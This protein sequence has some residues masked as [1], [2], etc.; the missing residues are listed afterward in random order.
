[1]KT[2]KTSRPA[3]RRLL[4]LL[5]SLALLL[6]A[7]APAGPVSANGTQAP[8]AAES[9]LILDKTAVPDGSG[10]YTIRLEAYTTGRVESTEKVVPTDIVLVLDQSGS[11]DDEITV[12]T[13]DYYTALWSNLN[14]VAASYGTLY[15]LDNGVYREVSVTHRTILGIGTYYYRYTDANG[16]QQT[17]ES[18]FWLGSV[19]EPLNGNLYAKRTANEQISRL[20]ALKDAAGIF[21]GQVAESAKGPDGIAG[22]DDDVNHRLA[23]VGFADSGNWY[24]YRNTELFVGKDAY[25]YGSDAPEHYGEALQDMSTDEGQ[26]NIAA[27]INELDANGA[28]Y[29]QYGMEMANGILNTVTDPER[30]KVVILFTDGYPGQNSSSYDADVANATI[31]QAN[32]AKS[33][34]AVVYAV[35]IFDGADPSTPG[36]VNGNAT[37]QSN[38]YMQQVS[39]NNGKVQ[40]PSYYLAASDAGSLNEIFEQISD[41]ISRPDISLGADT[42][43]RDIVSPYFT[44]PA[45]KA[46]ITVGTAAYNGDGTF[47]DPVPLADPQVELKSDGAMEVKGFDFDQNFVTDTAKA[48]GTYGSKLVITFTVRPKGGF[49]GGNSVP[50]NGEASGVYRGSGELVELFPQPEVN[51]PLDYD[52]ATSDQTIYLG[53]TADLAGRLGHAQ[54]YVPDGVNNAFVNIAYQVKDPA[55]TVVGAYT[56]PAGQ[57]SGFWAWAGSAS[58]A[59]TQDTRYTVECTV[60]PTESPEGGQEAL[61]V[62]GDFTVY[63]RSGSLTITKWGGQSGETYLFRILKDGAA[64]MTVPVE[65]G[66]S[67]TVVQLAKGN[68]TV[69]EDATWSWRYQSPRYNTQTVTF[70]GETVQAEVVCTNDDRDPYWL[71]GYDRA[72]NRKGGAD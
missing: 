24:G 66:G 41:S 33:G 12:G 5:L 18:G 3:G 30:N 6:A 43:I 36:D 52:Y 54:G 13:R 44:P 28:T 65:A 59:L 10:G 42:V 27:S 34:G 46:S 20:E 51:V 17:L 22:T 31:A 55:G 1:M 49:F 62:P 72:A 26:G 40:N 25:R 45:D 61:S 70:A 56:I 64:F 37:A 48:D 60:T 7:A 23:V 50:T 39:S 14:V 2:K 63:V 16:V 47:A 9:G 32:T 8:P 67:V 29:A 71:N 57:T 4:P 69:Q 53:E 19:P 58:P 15:Y 35:G 38:Y 11:M 21:A 68:Y